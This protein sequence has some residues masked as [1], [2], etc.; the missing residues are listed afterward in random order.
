M[1]GK[2]GVRA[3]QTHE[4][5]GK[6]G[7]GDPEGREAKSGLASSGRGFDT[8]G[9][10]GLF[11]DVGG[12]CGDLVLFEDP[13]G[14][15]RGVV[16][17]EVAQCERGEGGNREDKIRGNRAGVV[18]TTLRAVRI[19]DRETGRGGVEKAVRGEEVQSHNITPSEKPRQEGNSSPKRTVHIKGNA[20]LAATIRGG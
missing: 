4:M 10:K 8:S 5:K 20:R 13:K 3:H 6:E 16:N 7:S 9:E 18:E 15:C 11:P 1:E 14:V 19:Y 17:V 2:W 12:R